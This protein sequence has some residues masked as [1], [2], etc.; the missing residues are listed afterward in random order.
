VAGH[1]CFL[2]RTRLYVPTADLAVQHTEV[3][4]ALEA[5]TRSLPAEVAGGIL[6]CCIEVGS[7]EVLCSRTPAAAKRFAEGD[8][9]GILGAGEVPE[10]GTAVEDSLGVAG[11]KSEAGE[12]HSWAGG[13][14]NWVAAVEGKHRA[15]VLVRGSRTLPAFND[16]MT[17]WGGLDSS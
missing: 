9:L 13:V 7:V 4:R 11:H 16:G 1:V 6:H 17:D 3:L 10:A 8:S 12:G 5:H 15:A 2:A 14:R